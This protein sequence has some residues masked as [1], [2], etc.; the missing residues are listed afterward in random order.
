MYLPDDK[1]LVRTEDGEKEKGFVKANNGDELVIVLDR[2][3]ETTVAP[4]EHVQFIEKV[5]LLR[6][7]RN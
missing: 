1:V 2:N 5:T 7:R 4:L 6:I 3:R